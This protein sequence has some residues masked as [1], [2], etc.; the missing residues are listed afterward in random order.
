MD[1]NPARWYERAALYVSE[2]DD[3]CLGFCIAPLLTPVAAT[4]EHIDEGHLVYYR[5]FGR[6][7]GKALFD[8]Q[9]V[10]GHL[11]PYLYKYILGWPITFSDLEMVDE[12]NFN[13]LKQLETMHKTGQD[14][15]ALCLDFTTTQEVMGT[16]E[17]IELIKGGANVAVTNAIAQNT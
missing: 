6:I 1:I 2:E 8:G 7:M 4:I 9:L 10:A 3:T 13:D 17:E 15:E 14:I 12:K 5:F 11:A 16:K